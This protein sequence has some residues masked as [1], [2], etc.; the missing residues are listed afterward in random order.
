MRK[1]KL[2][3]GNIGVIKKSVDYRKFIIIMVVLYLLLSFL[4]MHAV[5]LNEE[6]E[7]LS[8]FNFPDMLWDHIVSSPLR[9]SVTGSTLKILGL[10]SV[11]YLLFVAYVRREVAR[12]HHDMKGIEKGSSEWNTNL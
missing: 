5:T 2:D 6:A 11:I 10:L 8:L 12:R 9:I 1:K 7:G 3:T 4:V